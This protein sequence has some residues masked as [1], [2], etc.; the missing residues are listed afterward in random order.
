MNHN[1]P[2]KP[3]ALPDNLTSFVSGDARWRLPDKP[4]VPTT[5]QGMHTAITGM[6]IQE[7][8]FLTTTERALSRPSTS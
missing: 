5:T 7:T 4:T 3:K 8:V 6:G 1:L 2:Q